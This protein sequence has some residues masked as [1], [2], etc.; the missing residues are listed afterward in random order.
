MP[1]RSWLHHPWSV[2]E[3]TSHSN[4]TCIVVHIWG[5]VRSCCSPSHITFCVGERESCSSPWGNGS[6]DSTSH[7]ALCKCAEEIRR[8]NHPGHISLHVGEGLGDAVAASLLVMEVLL[9]GEE[10]LTPDRI[11][12][13]LL[14]LILKAFHHCQVMRSWHATKA[15]QS[16]PSVTDTGWPSSTTRS[17]D[18]DGLIVGM[19]GKERVNEIK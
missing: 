9:A 19:E 2:G 4:P 1:Q 12:W 3:T 15:R 17:E 16:S 11:L 18:A 14:I 5:W 8:C 6:C 10:E 13:L 7:I